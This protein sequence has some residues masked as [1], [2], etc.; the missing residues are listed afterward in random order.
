MNAP[1]RTL[2]TGIA[3][4]DG[5]NEC[6]NTIEVRGHDCWACESAFDA[7]VRDKAALAIRLA[8]A[9]AEQIVAEGGKL[10]SPAVDTRAPYDAVFDYTAA[11]HTFFGRL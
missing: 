10:P 9:L 11:S 8:D 3:S 4:P 6:G 5:C 1:A 2:P 7:P